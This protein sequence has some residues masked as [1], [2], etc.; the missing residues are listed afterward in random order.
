MYL[1]IYIVCKQTFILNVIN[2][3]AAL[4][5]IKLMKVLYKTVIYSV[6]ICTSNFASFSFLE[7]LAQK[8]IICGVYMHST[9]K[10]KFQA[11]FVYFS[12]SGKLKLYLNGISCS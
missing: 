1:H 12:H 5:F 11:F 10:Y 8:K 3:F 2:L 4:V 6:I 7:N 9:F